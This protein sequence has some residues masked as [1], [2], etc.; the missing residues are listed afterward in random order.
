M[1][2]L[3]ELAYRPAKCDYEINCMYVKSAY[4]ME[5]SSLFVTYHY[6]IKRLG[7]VILKGAAVI[8]MGWEN[9]ARRLDK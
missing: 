4:K 1:N 8:E 2:E 5:T 3:S 7:Y 6:D 9:A